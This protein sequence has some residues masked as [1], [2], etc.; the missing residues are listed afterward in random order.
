MYPRITRHDSP[1][2]CSDFNH[3]MSCCLVAQSCPALCDPMV[4]WLLVHQ[5]PLSMGFSRQKY[6]SGLPVLAPGNLPNLGIKPGSLTLQADT[7]PSEPSG[8]PPN[9]YHLLPEQNGRLSGWWYHF[10]WKVCCCFKT[11]LPLENICCCAVQKMVILPVLLLGLSPRK[12]VLRSS[13]FHLPPCRQ[14]K[15]RLFIYNS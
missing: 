13:P 6:W 2:S 10:C 8:K 3:V 4:A 12:F 9:Q 11:L 1:S 15:Q 7:L 14:S 5:A